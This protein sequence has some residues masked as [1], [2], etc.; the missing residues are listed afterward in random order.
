MCFLGDSK[1][2]NSVH[3][4]HTILEILF[5]N[6]FLSILKLRNGEEK[7]T[8]TNREKVICLVSNAIATYSIY[9]KKG[10][11]PP[12]QSMIDFILKIMPKDI[13]S[14]ISMEMIDEVFEYVS[15]AHLELS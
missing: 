1:R 14:E 2:P 13:K 12:K 7:L 15:K 5:V 6:F 8:L 9:N 4:I 3:L 10:E 11:L